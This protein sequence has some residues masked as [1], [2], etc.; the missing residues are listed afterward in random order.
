M[1]T[2]PD[3]Y[4]EAIDTGIRPFPWRWELKRRSKPMGT[5]LGAGGYQSQASAQQAGNQALAR[6]LKDLAREEKRK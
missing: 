5:R 2:E 1:A 6:F 3:Y 4:V